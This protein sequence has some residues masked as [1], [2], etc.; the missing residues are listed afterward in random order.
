MPLPFALAS[1]SRGYAAL[2]PSI[3]RVGRDVAAATAA[4]L[5]QVLKTP[6][7]VSGRPSPGVSWPRTPAARLAIDLT[8]I[9]ALATLEVEPALVVR[10]LDRLAGGEGAVIGAASL[11]PL[12]QAAFEL[13]ALAA[14]EGACEVPGLDRL[15]A[16]RLGRELPEDAAEGVLGV[17]VDV[18]AGEVHG[19]ARLLVPE[20]ALRMLD[21]AA[22]RADSPLQLPASIRRGTTSLLPEE[23]E[24]LEPGD[25][26]LVQDPA[27]GREALV[28]PGGFR[29][30]GRLGPDG[31]HVEE[32]DMTG[33]TSQIPITLEVELCRVEVPLGELARLEPGAILPLAVDR[34][35]QVTLRAGDRAVAHGELVEVE[36]AIGV[37]IAALEAAP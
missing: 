22:E 29:A 13:L 11:T 1:V 3:R 9:P 30:T 6:V 36:G 37:R 26:L 19:R 2:S 23:L 18:A 34:R 28:L 20:A 27:D 32:T 31:F 10:L 16:P 4:A 35:G 21:A 17:E 14:V 8:E 25:V 15:L 24:A 33:R 5:H 7:A 12:E